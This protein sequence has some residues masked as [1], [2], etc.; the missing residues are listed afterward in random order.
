MF[1]DI[2]LFVFSHSTDQEF[3]NSTFLVWMYFFPKVLFGRLFAEDP[4]SQ[5]I[6]SLYS[7]WLLLQGHDPGGWRSEWLLTS[8]TLPGVNTSHLCIF[9]AY[10]VSCGGQSFPC[11]GVWVFGTLQTYITKLRNYCMVR[12]VKKISYN[13][14]IQLKSRE[15]LCYLLKGIVKTCYS[16][17]ISSGRLLKSYEALSLSF[18]SPTVSWGASGSL[19]RF[20]W[21]GR[22]V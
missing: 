20:L 9:T 13:M 21:E 3:S 14:N 15:F 6:Q 17:W 4:C 8:V 2:L 22:G 18:M 11:A 19:W 10:A 16:V 5:S 7:S 1:K 12:A